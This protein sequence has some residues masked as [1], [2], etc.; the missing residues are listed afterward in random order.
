MRKKLLTLLLVLAASTGA[1]FAY[2][3]K[4]GNLCYNI[5]S[6]D[7][8]TVEVTHEEEIYYK[9][10][11][12]YFYEFDTVIIPS[13]VQY[14]N[15]QY[16][17]VSIGVMA[18]SCCDNIKSLTIPNSVKSINTRAFNHTSV[19]EVHI[20]DIESWC[21]ISFSGYQAYDPY[22]EQGYTSNPLHR[23]AQL[24]VNDSL[25][26]DLIIPEEVTSI[27]QGTFNDCQALPSINIP[28]S[29]SSIEEKAFEEC[30]CLKDIY[31][32]A[33]VGADA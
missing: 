8:H 25:I 30:Y 21:A 18:F 17:V 15:D 31:C 2:D 22:Y 26:T 6:A 32:Y 5:L 10:D 11:R 4:S 24:F 13:I 27:E 20:Q 3:F 28:K 12:A 29:V 16:N 33:Q 19:D 14:N 1:N 23:G 7:N 9:S